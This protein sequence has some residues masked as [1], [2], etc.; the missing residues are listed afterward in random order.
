[1]KLFH[2]STIT[3]FQLKKKGNPFCLSSWSYTQQR[4]FEIPLTGICRFA[5]SGYLTNSV[6]RRIPHLRIERHLISDS[7]LSTV[8]FHSWWGCENE[9]DTVPISNLVAS[10]LLLIYFLKL[11]FTLGK[12]I[13]LPGIPSA[14]PN[15][16]V[17]VL[18]PKLRSQ[19]PCCVS[20][21][22]TLEVFS[23]PTVRSQNKHS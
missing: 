4:F 13:D 11:R 3:F 16:R 22:D 1:M 6:P 23:C 12:C 17:T 21:L 8:I 5:C 20:L 15:H 2:C 9:F 14:L 10:K 19:C 18:C 7:N